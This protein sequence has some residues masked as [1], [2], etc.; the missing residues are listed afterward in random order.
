[1]HNSNYFAGYF[2]AKRKIHKQ[3]QFYQPKTDRQLPE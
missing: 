3:I 1:M 2:F